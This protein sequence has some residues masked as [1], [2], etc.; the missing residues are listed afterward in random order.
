MKPRSERES[1]EI[2]ELSAVKR[3]TASSLGSANVE[4]L[5]H[6]VRSWV[7]GLR[8]HIK[9]YTWQK[10]IFVDGSFDRF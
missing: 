8:K 2:E 9:V 5:I 7:W 4:L 1:G 3:F 6:A 10:R